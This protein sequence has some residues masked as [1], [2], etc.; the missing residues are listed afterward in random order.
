MPVAPASGNTIEGGLTRACL[1]TTGRVLRPVFGLVGGVYLA[2]LP[3]Y[4]AMFTVGD[5]GDGASDA[6]HIGVIFFAVWVIIAVVVGYL[7]LLRDSELLRILRPARRRLSS[8]R[9]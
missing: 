7:T 1:T 4:Y 5:T 9:Q 6:R 2:A 8:A 3:T